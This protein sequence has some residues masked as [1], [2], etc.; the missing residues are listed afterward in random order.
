MMIAITVTDPVVLLLFYGGVAV[1][2]AALVLLARHWRR[3]RA[4]GPKQPLAT[5][6]LNAAPKPRRKALRRGLEV[7]ITTREE[8]RARYG[9]PLL[10][11]VKG[12]TKDG[13]RERWVLDGSDGDLVLW[14]EDGV[15]ERIGD[16]S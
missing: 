16:K 10:Q 3:L 4:P 1:L 9:E 8:V 2:L 15:L 13:T 12:M 7:G 14:F 5:R 11:E 6:L